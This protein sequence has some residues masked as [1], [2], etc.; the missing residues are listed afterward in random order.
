MKQYIMHTLLAG[1]W[2]IATGCGEKVVETN[3]GV[4]PQAG[5][6]SVF[7]DAPPAGTPVPIPEARTRLKP[8]DAVVLS[9]L[10]MGVSMPFVPGRGV[11]VLGDEATIVPCDVKGD[12]HCSRPWDACCDPPEVRAAGTAT[13]QVLDEDGRV[14]QRGL[15][16]INGLTELSRVTVAGKVADIATPEAFIVTATAIHVGTR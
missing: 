16:G 13:I 11:F 6:P 15:K 12:D 7:V 8:G 9:G 2:L 4:E 5:A 1:S 10:V 3:A 14:I